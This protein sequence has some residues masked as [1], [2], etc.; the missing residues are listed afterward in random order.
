M[1]RKEFVNTSK[2]SSVK[3]KEGFFLE[4]DTTNWLAQYNKKIENFNGKGGAF[5]RA[6]ARM[7]PSVKSEFENF[8]NQHNLTGRTKD[9]L[10]EQA[11][12]LWGDVRYYK[13]VGVN[14]AEKKGFKTTKKVVDKTKNI[15][16]VEYGFEID[17][18]G[19]G[20]IFLDI[21]RPGVKYKNGTTSKEMKPHFF[22]YYTVEKLIKPFQ[23]IFKEEVIK[24]LKKEGLM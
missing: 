5:E 12:M 2:G 18:G 21:G 3:R 4:F 16:F 17:K 13:N 19:E 11:N 14:E 22:V 9:A 10:M 20:A 15:L 24:D 23:D 7:I 1:A 6:V 8:I